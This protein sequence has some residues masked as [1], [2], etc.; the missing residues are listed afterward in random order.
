MPALLKC[1]TRKM[2]T[3]C[4]ADQNYFYSS[5]NVLIFS[6]DLFEKKNAFA[7]QQGSDCSGTSLSN[8]YY[9][10]A[11]LASERL[12]LRASCKFSV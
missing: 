11:L 2:D 1:V 4:A 5:F 3:S 9:S 12:N 10:S 8:V 6:L 7:H